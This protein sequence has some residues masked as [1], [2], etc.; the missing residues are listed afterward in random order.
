MGLRDEKKLKVEK[1]SKEE[2][3]G[4]EKRK[5]QRWKDGRDG[6]DG[7]SQWGCYLH[8]SGAKKQLRL[9]ISR[10]GGGKRGKK[11]SEKRENRK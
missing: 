1:E 10:Q 9:I 7:R 5:R 2:E 3:K 8:V 11:E 4:K 6:R